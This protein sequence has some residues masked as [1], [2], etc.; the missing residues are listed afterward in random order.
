MTPQIL[1]QAQ[2]VEAAVD[3]VRGPDA[4]SIRGAAKAYG[5]PFSA[6]HR[7]L[8]RSAVPFYNPKKRGRSQRLTPDEEKIICEAAIAFATDGTPLTKE[9][10]LDLAQTFISELSPQRQNE[11]AF[12]NNRPSKHW[13]KGFL[14][15]TGTLTLRKRSNLEAAR[16]D[17]VSPETVAIHFARIEA[18]CQLHKICNGRFIFN[19]D[20]SGL[21][22][23]TMTL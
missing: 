3:A 11:I 20:E 2:R 14:Q 5:V 19:L 22:L 1:P 16:A 13:R 6:V 10:L 12:V 15:R 7:A 17:A 4:P 21:S 23:R 8:K 18:L 9:C